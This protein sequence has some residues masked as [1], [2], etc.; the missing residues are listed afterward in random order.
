MSSSLH[1]DHKKKDILF[2]GEGPTQ[3]SDDTVLTAEKK[4]SITFTEHNKNFCLS[5]HYNGTNNY[6]FL[7]GTEIYEFKAR[8]SEIVV[9]PLCL[10]NISKAF[11]AGN[12]KK[13]GWIFMDVL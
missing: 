7:N 10:G 2:L 11:S 13:T 5:L 8:G 3:G 12:M 6:L 4:Y 9:T 1:V